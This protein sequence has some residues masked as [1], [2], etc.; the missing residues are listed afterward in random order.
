MIA[1]CSH[2]REQ[3]KLANLRDISSERVT[4]CLKAYWT[5]V[6]MSDVLRGCVCF[7]HCRC[8]EN[9]RKESMK[10]TQRPSDFI[11][12]MVTRAHHPVWFES[13]R[14]QYL[15]GAVTTAL[16]SS[17]DGCLTTR[18][19]ERPTFLTRV[20]VTA[21]GSTWLLASWLSCPARLSFTVIL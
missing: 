10:G 13:R 18:Q 20:H 7:G 8:G 2:G 21:R 9:G 1:A 11:V 16:N 3:Q 4:G 17:L 5:K 6:I 19:A 15:D 14:C 12:E